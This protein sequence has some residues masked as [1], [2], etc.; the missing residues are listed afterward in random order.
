[1]SKR[2]AWVEN[3]P[4]LGREYPSYTGYVGNKNLFEVYYK[5][6]HGWVARSL[7]FQLL[8]TGLTQPR[9][10]DAAKTA[11]ERGLT[12]FLKDINAVYVD[13]DKKPRRT[14]QEM[15]WERLTDEIKRFE[16]DE[17]D[18]WISVADV[19]RILRYIRRGKKETK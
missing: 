1:M 14:P 11:C 6:H 4:I 15:A 8:D 19:I 10:A 9:S 7:Y 13:P 12:K 17:P 16:L 5:P 18:A 2:I 3:A